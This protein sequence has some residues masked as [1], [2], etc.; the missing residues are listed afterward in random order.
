[1]NVSADPMGDVHEII[2][3]TFLVENSLADFVDFG[4]R[5]A[6]SQGVQHRVHGSPHAGMDLAQLGTG[7]ADGAYRRGAIVPRDSR[8]RPSRACTELARSTNLSPP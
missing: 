4:G 1:M 3:Q 5:G 8:Y 6:R 2:G 7:R